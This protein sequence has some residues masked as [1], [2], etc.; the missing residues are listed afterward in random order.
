MTGGGVSWSEY[1]KGCRIHPNLTNGTEENKAPPEQVGLQNSNDN[2][3]PYSQPDNTS[4]NFKGVR[5]LTSHPWTIRVPAG[6]HELL[7][8]EFSS[9]SFYASTKHLS[10]CPD[11]GKADGQEW[12]SMVKLLKCH[13][14]RQPSPNILCE[15]VK[16]ASQSTESLKGQDNIRDFP[17]QRN[18]INAVNTEKPSARAHTYKDTR[19]P[20]QGERLYEYNDYGEDISQKANLY[21]H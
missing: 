17:V 13:C 3:S 6:N 11:G 5:V 12:V 19:Q 7:R 2:T 8:S 18:P 14:L 4:H 10:L 20:I 9:P 21:T 1:K 15:R 16:D